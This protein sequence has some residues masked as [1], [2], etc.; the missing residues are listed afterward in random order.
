VVAGL[1]AWPAW[2]LLRGPGRPRGPIRDA[3]AM[4]ADAANLVVPS[5]LTAIRPGT[6]ALA[7]AMRAYPGEQGSYLGVAMLAV[8]LA[9]V[10]LVRSR[11]VVLTAVV[12]VLLGVA[13]LGTSVAVLGH[14]TGIPLPWRALVDL[15]LVGQAEAGRLA[16]FVALGVVAGAF[17]HLLIQVPWLIREHVQYTPRLGL[18]D[19]AVRTVVRLMLPRT[20]GIAAVQINFLINTVLAS[21]LPEGRLAAL[22]YAFLL[23][24]LPEGVIAQSIAT[25]LF[26]TFSRLAARGETYALRHAFSTAFCIT[27]YLTIPASLGLFL[28]RTQLVQLLLQRGAFTADSTTQTAF[29]LQFFALGLF[30][31]SGLEILTRAFY[32]L[33]DTATPVKI[34][35]ASVALNIVLSLALLGSLAQGGLALANSIAT[36]LEMLTLLYLLKV[37]M[38]GV[39]LGRILASV[40]KVT[41]ACALM[42]V[43]ILLVLSTGIVTNLWLMTLGAMAIGAAVFLAVTFI[44]KSDEVALAWRLVRQRS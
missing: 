29:A 43:A 7:T 39:D 6:D 40:A 5:P 31:H 19:D 28:L 1:C 26:P 10:V 36:I 9:A 13:S 34:A 24:L 12:T 44:L 32:A 27:L 21:T 41:I 4:G 16:P 30:A 23:I 11:A 35:L 2:V 42:G 15:P 25:V 3:A 33:H 22:N 20:A 17:L 8:F 38:G 18:D 14:D 37:R